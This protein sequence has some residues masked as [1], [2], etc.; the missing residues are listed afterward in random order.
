MF[1]LLRYSLV[2]LRAASKHSCSKSYYFST[3]SY[4][5]NAFYYKNTIILIKDTA[6]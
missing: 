5:G 6:Y 3:T 4:T 2:T 1:P